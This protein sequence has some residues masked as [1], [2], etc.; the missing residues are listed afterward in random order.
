MPKLYEDSKHNIND[1][2][3]FAPVLSEIAHN[4]VMGSKKRETIYAIS[5]NTPSDRMFNALSDDRLV[6]YG[7]GDIQAL[8]ILAKQYFDH[9]K[10]INHANI[11]E[12]EMLEGCKRFLMM[13]LQQHFFSVKDYEACLEVALTD[14]GLN[15]DAIRKI[16]GGENFAEFKRFFSSLTNVGP[17][18]KTKIKTIWLIN[19]IKEFLPNIDENVVHE[20]I[21]GFFAERG[22]FISFSEIKKQSPAVT[23]FYLPFSVYDKEKS[24]FNVLIDVLQEHVEHLSGDGNFAEGLSSLDK[25][26]LLPLSKQQKS[27][28]ADITKSFMRSFLS[29]EF[30]TGRFYYYLGLYCRHFI[31]RKNKVEQKLLTSDRFYIKEFGL[32]KYSDIQQK[33]EGFTFEGE[34]KKAKNDDRKIQKIIE[35]TILRRMCKWMVHKAVRDKMSIIYELDSIE[36]STVANKALVALQGKD[37]SN[38]KIPICTSELREIFRYIDKFESIRFFKEFLEVKAPWAVE[39][40]IKDDKDSL[41]CWARYAIYLIFKMVAKYPNDMLLLTKAC[42][43]KKLLGAKKFGDDEINYSEIIKR[44]SEVKPSQLLAHPYDEIAPRKTIKQSNLAPMEVEELY[45]NLQEFLTIITLMTKVESER[46]KI[47]RAITFIKN[48]KSSNI[49]LDISEEDNSNLVGLD[50]DKP[51]V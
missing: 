31:K 46:K 45:N 34:L 41:K 43:I 49:K 13:Q 48:N 36:S 11:K 7:S 27:G 29:S 23:N 28:N 5:T 10:S 18:V 19:A 2:I 33:L 15:A 40:T 32:G 50:Q 35:G 39:E 8:T 37:D 12:R 14:I 25:L 22:K 17:D 1:Y 16:I 30:D 42:E 9:Y 21:F 4:V 3:G 38:T 24:L 20:K 6:I 51:K 44:Y 47:N 26:K